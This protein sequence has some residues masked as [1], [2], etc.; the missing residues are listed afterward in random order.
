VLSVSIGRDV[1]VDVASLDLVGR[2]YRNL[3]QAVSRTH[4]A[5]V[6][7]RIVAESDLGPELRQELL[8]VVAARP[9]RGFAMILDHPVDGTHPGTY[10]AVARDRHGRLA[11]FQRFASSDDGRELSLDIPYR[12][13]DAPNGVDERLTVDTARWLAARGGSQ[14]SLAFAAF[15]EVFLAGRRTG[16]ARLAYPAIRLLDPF[17]RLEPLNRYLRKFH[18]LGG[19]RYAVVRPFE[20]LGAGAAMLA[21]EFTPERR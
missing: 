15:P 21:L 1:V 7:T 8:R 3:R 16:W 10:V 5:G 11:G 9:Q 6:T 12:L 4:N 14:V 19:R 2:R 18:A 20:L 13:P 17:I